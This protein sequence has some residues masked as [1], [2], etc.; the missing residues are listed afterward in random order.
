MQQS[1]KNETVK[2]SI[3]LRPFTPEELSINSTTQIESITNN[4]I[5]I[6][7]NFEQK[8]YTFDRIFSSSS[9]QEE[10]FLSVKDIINVN[11]NITI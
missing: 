9:S 5:S 7:K 1:P 11:T 10:V 3:R 8:N 2:V 4:S 6:K